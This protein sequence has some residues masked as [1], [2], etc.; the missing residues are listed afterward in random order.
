MS[1]FYETE[2]VIVDFTKVRSLS[3]FERNDN[4]YDIYIN[5]H[6]K[7]RSSDNNICKEFSKYLKNRNLVK[8]YEKIVKKL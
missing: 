1:S 7:H 3:C 5:N 8:E 6:N 4:W 2:K